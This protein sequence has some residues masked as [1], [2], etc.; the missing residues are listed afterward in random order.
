MVVMVMTRRL[1]ATPTTPT[2]KRA[3][4]LSFAAASTLWATNF[5]FCDLKSEAKPA[6]EPGKNCSRAQADAFLLGADCVPF[7]FG[8]VCYLRL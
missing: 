7:S 6:L 5:G 4:L 3:V 2:T 1:A 8:N